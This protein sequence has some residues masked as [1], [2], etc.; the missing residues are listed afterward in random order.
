MNSL[1]LKA[2]ELAQSDVKQAKEIEA[3]LK[4]EAV[5]VEAD[6]AK[7]ESPTDDK[8]NTGNCNTGYSN[9]GYWNTGYWNTGNWNTGHRNTGNRNTGNR[10]TGHS[11]TGN[12]NTG[13]SNTGNWNTG[14]RNTGNRNTGNRNTGNC[15]TGHSNTGNWNTTNFSNGFFNTEEVEIINVFDKPCMKSVW[16]E[17][18]KP[19]CLYFK[20]TE[21]IDE[22]DMSDVEKQ[23]NPSFSCT[24]GYLKKYDYKE[25]FTKSVTEA[26]KEERDLIR[27]LP[28]FNNEKFL[29]ISGVDLS[30][31]D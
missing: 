13:H 14:N 7:A 8:G 11:N 31:L 22:S 15:N 20:L 23:E 12:W 26:S 6:T 30:Q 27:A 16:D 21:W 17:A 1:K 4:D 28:N 3:Y 5:V 2:I 10:N 19:L 24:G 9:T 25:A 18:S 29:E